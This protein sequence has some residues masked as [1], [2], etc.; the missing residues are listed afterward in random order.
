MAAA[1]ATALVAGGVAAYAAIPDTNGR[2]SGCYS[3]SNGALRVVD[4]PSTYSQP[5]CNTG[6]APLTWAQRGQTGPTG[7]RGPQGPAGPVNQHW[8]KFSGDGRLL[9]ASEKPAAVYAYGM[10]GYNYVS[11]TGVDVSK[12]AI[13][14][15]AGMADTSRYTHINTA[16]Y[17]YSNTYILAYTIDDAGNFVGGIPMDVTANCTQYGPYI[18]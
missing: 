15:T 1:T 18:P 5:T 6:E 2:V 11:F 17:N 16:Y 3:T 7:M 13:T 14:V 4:N 10:S 12:C 9:A 8:A